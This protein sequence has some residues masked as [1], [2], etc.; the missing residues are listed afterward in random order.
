MS[1]PFKVGADD[2]KVFLNYLAKVYLFLLF[3]TLIQILRE[4]PMLT[5]LFFPTT[6]QQSSLSGPVL[7]RILLIIIIVCIF[8]KFFSFLYGFHVALESE[9][10]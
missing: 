2:Y 10:K 5:S 4:V 1:L 8:S 3:F 6:C 9:V 7:L